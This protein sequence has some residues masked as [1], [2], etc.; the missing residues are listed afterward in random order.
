[1]PQ[2]TT[3]QTSIFFQKR[4][5]PFFADRPPGSSYRPR[6]VES[7]GAAGIPRQPITSRF[8]GYPTFAGRPCGWGAASIPPQ[9]SWGK[10]GVAG[11]LIPWPNRDGRTISTVPLDATSQQHHNQLAT[12]L[13]RAETAGGW[14][15]GF[16]FRRGESMYFRRS[17][18]WATGAILAPCGR[19][20]LFRLMTPTNDIVVN[21]RPRWRGWKRPGDRVAPSFLEGDF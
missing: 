18:G 16:A 8:V 7:K 5:T 17:G 15:G 21:R 14:R 2:P 11:G 13:A 3:G 6:R 4:G 20:R 1:M 9:R 12:A 10:S 19:F